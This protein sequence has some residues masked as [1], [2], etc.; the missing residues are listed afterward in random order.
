MI[1]ELVFFVLESAPFRPNLHL[2]Y[3]HRRKFEQL[4]PIL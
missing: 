1:L 2:T 4:N 3:I